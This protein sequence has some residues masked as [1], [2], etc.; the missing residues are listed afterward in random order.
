[1][2]ESCRVVGGCHDSDTHVQQAGRVLAE[3]GLGSA[4]DFVPELGDTHPN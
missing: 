2:Q 4:V 1:M 3:L